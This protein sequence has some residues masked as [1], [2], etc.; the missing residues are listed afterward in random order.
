[1]RASAEAAVKQ[2]MV[3]YAIAQAE[4]IS[5]SEEE[6]K[7]AEEYYLSYYGAEDVASMCDSLDVTVE[8][9]NNMI[10]FSVIYTA[11]MDFLT[12]NATY[13]GAK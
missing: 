13:A 7:A 2:E 8:Y 11:V 6:R 5:G 10:D 1:M 4:N 9:F 12:E 3:L